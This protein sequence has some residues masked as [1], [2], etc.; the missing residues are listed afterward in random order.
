M[1]A[2]RQERTRGQTT[3]DQPAIYNRIRVLRSERGI[4]QM[5][6]AA[7]VGVNHRTIG[8]IERQQSM[9][10]LSLAWTISD[11]FE[12]PLEVVFSRKPFGAMSQQLYGSVGGC[13]PD[14][15]ATART[16]PAA[17]PTGGGS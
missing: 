1:R 10:S 14:A 2:T 7:A 9:P 6:L 5:E 17:A 11:Y 13:S 3:T 12:L 16:L 4:S 15:A 8:Y